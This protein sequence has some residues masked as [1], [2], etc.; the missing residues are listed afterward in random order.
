MQAV[1]LGL[2]GPIQLA[3]KLRSRLAAS[4]IA[5]GGSVI[6]LPAAR[7]WHELVREQSPQEYAD[8]VRGYGTSWARHGV[9][10]NAVT[11]FPTVPSQSPARSDSSTAGGGAALRTLVRPTRADV[12][13]ELAAISLF[14]GSVGA[15]GLTGQTLTV[16][17]TL[18]R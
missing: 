18:Q 4:S 11:A 1:R 16:H 17:R 6:A 10:F 2:A 5:G 13:T 9:R 14:L 12:D 3:T 8:T 15:S 7:G